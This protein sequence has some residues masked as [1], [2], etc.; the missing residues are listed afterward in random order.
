MTNGR[1]KVHFDN[2]TTNVQPELTEEQKLKYETLKQEVEQKRKEWEDNAIVVKG[3]PGK[4]RVVERGEDERLFMDKTLKEEWENDKE[5]ILYYYND[6]DILS[7][8]AG[9]ILKKSNGE[10]LQ[11]V[12]MMS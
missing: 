1:Y 4:C 9:Y 8:S 2:I 7:G 10:M 11:Q 5:S 3:I 12:T 6:I